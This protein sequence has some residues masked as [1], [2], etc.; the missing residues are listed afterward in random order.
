MTFKNAKNIYQ[1]II[2]NIK[3]EGL[4]KEERI[5]CSK[6]AGSIDVKFPANSEAKKIINM[7]ANNYLGLSNHPEIIKA[8][9]EGL[10]SRGYGMSSVRFICGTQDIHKTLE[11]KLSSFRYGRQHFVCKLF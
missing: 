8:A 5:I 2:D 6:Q 4:Y 11:D 1:S 9:H 3:A 10:D 7:C